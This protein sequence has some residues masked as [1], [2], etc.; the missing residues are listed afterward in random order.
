[1]Y[2][3]NECIFPIHDS[4]LSWN[5]SILPIFSLISSLYPPYP[6]YRIS[7]TNGRQM[8]PAKT[9]TTEDIN[10]LILV[11]AISIALLIGR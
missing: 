6:I 4:C 1:M 9:K 7:I 11:G 5:I 2:T 8:Y 10:P 3:S